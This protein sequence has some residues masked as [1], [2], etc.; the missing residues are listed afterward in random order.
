M[1]NTEQEKD[2]I[3]EMWQLVTQIT[4]KI[5]ENHPDL[6]ITI[7]NT[8]PQFA[9]MPIEEYLTTEQQTD[10]IFE[11]NDLL[12]GI[13]TRRNNQNDLNHEI[14]IDPKVSKANQQLQSSWK[15]RNTKINIKRKETLPRRKIKEIWQQL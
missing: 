4:N 6:V 13:T 15:Q 11:E 10:I 1:S 5:K 9:I 3:T 8:G 7:G 14:T 12:N 2:T